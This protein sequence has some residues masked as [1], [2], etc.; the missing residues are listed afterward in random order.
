ML[1]VYGDDDWVHHQHYE[2]IKD[3]EPFVTNVDDVV[4]PLQQVLMDGDPEHIAATS[5]QVKV[6]RSGHNLM[7]DNHHRC[8]AY[9]LQFVF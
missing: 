8:N 2:H 3:F 4:T 5:L 9:I 6:E 1:F 7:L